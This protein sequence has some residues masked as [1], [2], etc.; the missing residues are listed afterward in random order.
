MS[1]PERP[2]ITVFQ[3]L[4][5]DGRS[6][7]P[8]E[9]DLARQQVEQEKFDAVVLDGCEVGEAVPAL[10]VWLGH[11]S[12]AAADWK[13]AHASAG[14]AVIFSTS[15]TDLDPASM[16]TVIQERTELSRRLHRLRRDLQVHRLL[17]PLDCRLTPEL[18]TRDL[19]DE[20]RLT[21]RPRVVGSRK[22]STLS[23]PPGPSLLQSTR[24]NLRQMVRDEQS[25]SLIYRRV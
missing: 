17:C 22:A 11:G 9:T 7:P 15:P 24:W 20:L 6:V 1:A 12:A 23:G 18:I 21:L 2:H 4:S 3:I 14:P 19:V 10:S 8:T 13:R 16:L 5:I 25:C